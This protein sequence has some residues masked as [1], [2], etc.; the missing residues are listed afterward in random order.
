M[1]EREGVEERERVVRYNCQACGSRGADPPKSKKG[2]YMCPEC[3]DQVEIS[4]KRVVPKK[5]KK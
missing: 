4:E 1:E 5:E 2:N 3:G